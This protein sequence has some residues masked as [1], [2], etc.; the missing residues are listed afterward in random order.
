M[1]FKTGSYACMGVNW[2]LVLPLIFGVGLSKPYLWKGQTTAG[3]W[4]DVG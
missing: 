1:T 4:D 2:S 3:T